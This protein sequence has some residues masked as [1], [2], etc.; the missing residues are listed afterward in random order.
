MVRRVA[1]GPRWGSGSA[2]RRCGRGVPATGSPAAASRAAGRGAGEAAAVAV[3]GAAGEGVASTPFRCRGRTRSRER[4]TRRRKSPAARDH[5]RVGSLAV[6]SVPLARKRARL[7]ASK[8]GEH[9]RPPT[10]VLSI[11]VPMYNE[12]GNVAPLL[13]RIVAIVEASPSA[14][15]Y[16]IVLVNDGSTDGDRRRDSRGD[17][18]ASPHRARQPVA[19]LRP[20]AGRDRRHRARRGRRRRA[21]GRRSARPARTDRGLSGSKWREGYDVVYAVRRTRKGESAFKLLTARLVLP[22]RSSA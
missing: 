5:G 7:P 15:S 8:R 9:D 3:A 16:E 13:E 19:Q 14:A 21:D 2:S 4:E 22:H 18:A 17:G 20:P 1:A 10:P 11:V 6:P 12:E